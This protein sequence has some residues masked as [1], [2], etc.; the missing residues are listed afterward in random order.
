MSVTNDFHAT[1]RYVGRIRPD[2]HGR[3]CQF[4]HGWRGQH[5]VHNVKVVF[6]DGDITVC[7]LRCLRRI[8]PEPRARQDG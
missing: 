2:W 6:A 5:A 4:I 8:R 1:H 3:P 7:P